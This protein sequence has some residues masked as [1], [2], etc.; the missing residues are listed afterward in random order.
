MDAMPDNVTLA[1]V[2]AQLYLWIADVFDRS[3]APIGS[4]M[5]SRSRIPEGELQAAAEWA[6]ALADVENGPV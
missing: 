5:V 6:L 4:Y 2:I 3:P 1:E